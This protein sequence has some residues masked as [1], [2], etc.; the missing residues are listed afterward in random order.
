MLTKEYILQCLKDGYSISVYR[1]E[2]DKYSDIFKMVDGCFLKFS[3]ATGIYTY[4]PSGLNWIYFL[5]NQ[6]LGNFR[7]DII[8]FDRSTRYVD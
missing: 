2:L 7:I 3:R 1:P 8:K 4:Y 6:G 5:I